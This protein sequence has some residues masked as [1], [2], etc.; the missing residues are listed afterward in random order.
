MYTLAGKATINTVFRK[1]HTMKGKKFV[2]K[3]TKSFLLKKAIFRKGCVYW[4]A[5]RK[6][7]KLGPH[8][9][10]S[11]KKLGVNESKHKEAKGDFLCKWWKNIPSVLIP[12]KTNK[13]NHYYMTKM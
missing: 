6:K 9:K 12:L 5:N 1:W 13:K 4:K 2:P 10:T 3:R 7:Q 11:L 8:E